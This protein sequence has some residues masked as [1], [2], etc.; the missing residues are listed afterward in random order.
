MLV[1]ID[2]R[3]SHNGMDFDR[4]GSS[5]SSLAVIVG[6]AAWVGTWFLLPSP[7]EEEKFQRIGEGRPFI[8]RKRSLEIT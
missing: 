2:G 6:G 7:R 1:L 5:E 8:D 3:Q 4:F